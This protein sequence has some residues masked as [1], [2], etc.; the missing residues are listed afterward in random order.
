MRFAALAMVAMLFM[1][2]G[3]T[4]SITPPS[5]V[6]PEAIT[7]HEPGLDHGVTFGL[8]RPTDTVLSVAV[9]LGIDIFAF[10]RAP[11][12]QH[13][14]AMAGVVQPEGITFDKS[15]IA[16]APVF[17]AAYQADPPHVKGFP[18]DA[19]CTVFRDG[20]Q[21]RVIFDCKG[22]RWRDAS[23]LAAAEVMDI[24]LNANGYYNESELI[25]ELAAQ[26]AM[27]TLRIQ[28]LEAQQ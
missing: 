4:I 20:G 3:E 1:Q 11:E 21:S 27:L 18:R 13:A 7:V 23:R 25:R 6:L 2:S 12:N 24:E 22:D 15:R 8:N 5:G 9:G 19:N 14:L 26:V 16:H 10:T 17:I 28:Q